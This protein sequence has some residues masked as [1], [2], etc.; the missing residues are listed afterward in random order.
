MAVLTDKA[1]ELQ[2]K[3]CLESKSNPG[4]LA[5]VLLDALSSTSKARKQTALRFL[6]LNPEW[7]IWR[8][9]LE[10]WLR[11]L[12]EWPWALILSWISHQKLSFTL[13]EKEI[14]RKVLQKQNQMM[15]LAK[16]QGW[17]SLYD[18]VED[19]KEK[20]RD[21]L[22][23]KIKSIRTLLYE[24]L[25]TWKSQR[26]REQ[27]LKVLARLKKKFP[28]DM[29]I[30]HDQKV[31]RENQALEKLQ[32][33]IRSKR[34]QTRSLELP[35]ANESLPEGL[36][37]ALQKA[38]EEN[39]ERFYDLAIFCCFV[40]D[41]NWAFHMVRQ[42]PE[43][44]NRDWLEVEILIKLERFV[45]VLQALITLET[46][47]AQDP[48]T[49]FGTAYARAQ[50]FYGLGKKERA[51]EVLESLMASRPTYRQAAEL[52]ALWRNPS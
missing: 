33:R 28:Q 3:R 16:G 45:D 38:G 7:L 46:R 21:E 27:E 49:F 29:D 39:P 26:L 36:K 4:E 8:K 44:K 2:L 1:L 40:E 6:Q 17:Q 35:F 12:S 34:S 11:S 47:W 31:F 5:S 25:Q 51:L 19:L 48:E 10:P 18:E 13:D 24:E 14:I 20:A 42:A 41:W 9:D 37:Q 15:C 52:L 30:E 22:Q 32:N 23:A 50:A 43:S